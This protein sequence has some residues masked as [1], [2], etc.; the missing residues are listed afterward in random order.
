MT[1]PQVTQIGILDAQVCVPSDWTDAQAEAF[2]NADHPAGTTHGWVV[3][4]EGDDTLA[5][6]PE[7][8]PCAEREGFVHMR[9]VC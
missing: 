3:C 6:A 4:H 9:L 8:V 5:G 7:R 2:I 1:A